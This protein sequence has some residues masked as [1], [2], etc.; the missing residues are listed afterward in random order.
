MK[1]VLAAFV[2]CIALSP[3]TLPAAQAGE[4]AQALPP[5]LVAEDKGVKECIKW[6]Q[7][8]VKVWVKDHYEVR[9]Q[10][11]CLAVRG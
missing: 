4:G 3:W 8:K 9:T 11:V 2:L 6:V 5:V 7:R 10:S 1:T